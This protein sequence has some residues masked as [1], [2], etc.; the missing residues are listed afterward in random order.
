MRI[1]PI[2]KIIPILSTGLATYIGWVLGR[3]FGI[4][5]AFIVA[6]VVAGIAWYASKK[7]VADNL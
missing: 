7:W 2:Q 1:A 5:T 3:R 6:V 4:F